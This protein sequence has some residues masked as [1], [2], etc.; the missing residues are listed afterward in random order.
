MQGV[1]V[2]LIGAHCRFILVE[3]RIPASMPIEVQR[4]CLKFFR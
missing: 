1:I 4:T 3:A 2:S